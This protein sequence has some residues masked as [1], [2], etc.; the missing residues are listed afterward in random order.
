MCGAAGMEPP[1]HLRMEADLIERLCREALDQPDRHAALQFL[2]Q[3]LPS[4]DTAIPG[5]TNEGLLALHE[6]QHGV[7]ERDDWTAARR[8][9]TSAVGKRGKDILTSL[10]FRIEQIDNLTF[11]LRA[12]G[13]SSALAVLLREDESPE[14]GNDR[15]NSLSPVSYALKKADD[16]NLPLG[17]THAGKTVATLCGQGRCRC[18]PNAGAPRHMSNVSHRCCLKSRCLI[19][20]CFSLR[21]LLRPMEVSS[22]SC[23][24]HNAS[25]AILPNV[26]A[27]GFTTA[28]CPYW[29][30]VSLTNRMPCRRMKDSCARTRWL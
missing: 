13:R 21:R 20:G 30:Q 23:R 17:F 19:C 7:P 3:A 24:I 29:R 8:K 14:A 6:L 16:E 9:A 27:S 11:R 28:S 18:R 25:Q 5:L 12:D 10:G 26:C 2:S 4:L 15:F 22:E 1:V